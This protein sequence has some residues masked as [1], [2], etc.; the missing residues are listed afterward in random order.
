VV[1][2]NGIVKLCDFGDVKELSPGSVGETYT[3][4]ANY[5]APERLGGKDHSK[6]ADIWSVGISL[7]EIRLA[8]HPDIIVMED[9]FELIESRVSSAMV[10]FL[11]LCL[12]NEAQKRWS[13]D[14]L[15]VSQYVLSKTLN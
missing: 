3:G 7:L 5:L 2:A 6:P 4:T 9:L 15:L 8:K 1:G 11:K 13:A 10:D 12:E 14:N